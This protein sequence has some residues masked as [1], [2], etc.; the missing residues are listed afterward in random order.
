MTL[1]LRLFLAAIFLSVFQCGLTWA[2][3]AALTP[4]ELRCEGRTNPCGI[5]FTQPA[6]A[7]K[8]QA[9]DASRRGLSQRAYQVLVA[10]TAG[11][12][13]Q[14][15]GDLWDS[16]QVKSAETQRIHYAGQ[17]LQSAQRVFWKVR[18]WDQDKR[19]SAWSSTAEWAMG[20]LT[21]ADWKGAQWI[22]LA[23]TNAPSQLLRREFA[24][25]GDLIR[26][27]VHSSGLGQYEL[28]LNGVKVGADLLT[29]GWTDYRKTVLYDTYDVTAQLRA[30]SN[31]IGMTL[32]NGMYSVIKTTGRYN[33]FS[34]RM[35]SPKAIALLRL[36]YAGGRAE[37]V[38]TD[39]QWQARSGPFTY[40]DVYG[41]E[42]FDARLYPQ[43]WDQSR[44][45]NSE[46]AAA[47]GLAAPAG[48][49][50]GL[51]GAGWPIRVIETLE[52]VTQQEIRPGVVVYD[53]G[54]N[55]P[56]MPR[57][58]V[59]GPEG[60]VVK[61]IPAEL[62]KSSG[63]I[64]DPVCGGKSFW[65][66]TLAGKETEAWAPKFFYR[67]ARYLQ[68][69]LQAAET[70]GGAPRVISLVADVVHAAVPATGTFQTSSELFNRI[71]TLVRWAQ[72]GNMMSVLTDCPHREKLG[73]LEQ[74]Y[75]NGPALR[76]NFD[77]NPLFEKVVHDIQ[78]SQQPDGLVPNIA[79]E[80]TV[81][82]WW[83][84]MQF[85]ETP[86][87]GSAFIQIAWQQYLF[88][89]DL[90]LARGHYNGMKRY[91]DYL[92][93]HVGA[94]GILR[95]KGSLGD[96][97]D[98]GPK[99]PG[100]AQLTPV[101]LTATAIYYDDLQI[102][103]TFAMQTGRMDEAQT[104]RV[105]AAETLSAFQREY[106]QPERGIYATGSQ[107]ANAM[108]SALGL[109][110]FEQRGRVV[111]AI[112]TDVQQ[113][114]LTAGDVGYRY[115]LRALADG[116]RSDVVFA[117]N[118]QSEKPGYG[119]QLK[120]GATSLTEAWDA[121]RASSQNH[122]MLG[123]INEWFF[124]DLAGIQPDPVAPGFQHFLIKPAVVKDLTWVL[125]NYESVQGEI[126]SEWR[127]GTGCLSCMSSC[128][129]IRQQRS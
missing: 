125:A 109:V 126:R 68:V 32:G 61:I 76:Y 46:W 88:T 21:E 92:Q 115:L 122:F 15:R 97:Y 16:G 73:W 35:G 12:L 108:S 93:T 9:A 67:G 41:G 17:P 26:A 27:V 42:D 53:F 58:K 96:W 25:R 47:I 123:Q 106:F 116:G 114:G 34:G 44:F 86:E 103:T 48:R 62:R 128:R 84:D 89:G 121:R 19:R 10:S 40:S 2:A 39:S 120:M 63:E 77:L 87:W 54:Q 18:V 98:I 13:A 71:F 28:S 24:V 129:L 30:G 57:L 7:W 36:E 110:A 49:L 31:V 118:H 111:E 5:D 90:D 79:P 56:L 78:D 83:G 6:L 117:M 69:E 72:R 22:A 29:P 100:R 85:R 94:D 1:R 112:V 95:I 11:I 70:N 33:K 45:N 14:D 101:E 113:N 37:F 104:F 43:G 60:A 91:L 105:R 52:P 20:V 80:Y 3:T 66:Y 99:A 4:A 119:Y 81:F 65:T 107:T 59:T 8:V 38:R 55:A 127:R 82:D 51:S 74:A 124:H 64:D 75:L 50:T 102:M 23:D